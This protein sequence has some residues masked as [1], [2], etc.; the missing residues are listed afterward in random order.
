MLMTRQKQ[1][2]VLMVSFWFPPVNL[3]GAARVDKFA[4]YLPQYGWEPI[5]LTVDKLKRGIPLTRP[6]ETD[7]SKVARTPYFGIADNI[8]SMMSSNNTTTSEGKPPA[9]TFKKAIYD[10]AIAHLRFFYHMPTVR[11]LVTDPIGWYP[12]AVRRGLE[13]I[14][15]S[16]VDVIYSTYGPSTSHLIASK[17]HKE[18]GIPWV[19]D[20]RDL[21]SLDPRYSKIQPLQFLQEWIEKRV[22]KGCYKIITVEENAAAQLRSFHSK[23]VA[24][25]HNGFDAEDYKD[26][27]PLSSIFTISFTGSITIV[28]RQ[29]C[30]PFLEAVYELYREGR[31]SP[32]NF[33]ARF[34]GGNV[35]GF[36]VANSLLPQIKRL[37]IGQLVT[38]HETVPYK[39]CI[40]IQKEST[41]LLLLVRT[42]SAG[43]R[44]YT[45]RIFEYLGAGRPIL[46]V[47]P[48]KSA[49]DQLLTK[50]GAGIV[51]SQKGEIKLILAKWLDEFQK[52]GRITSHYSPR[53]E[54]IAN[55]TRRE[56]TRKLAKELDEAASSLK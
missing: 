24:L 30:L 56:Q 45:G 14:N 12:Y 39:E 4:K 2:R 50:S 43:R 49:V 53:R 7:S 25:I 55:Y 34:F 36:T 23:E 10:G 46:A 37:G 11:M 51:C 47:A 41:A 35:A 33:K 54:V 21:W 40:K 44:I 3:V 15:N 16:S 5:V 38:V 1:K 17:L 42:D 22:I 27:V 48:K 9:L 28:D 6:A 13:I 19:A 20:F 29:P 52:H 8:L 32:D 18:T 26:E 31:I